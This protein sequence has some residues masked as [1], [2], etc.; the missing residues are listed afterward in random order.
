MITFGV[1][2][3]TYLAGWIVIPEEGEGASIAENLI[4]KT[5]SS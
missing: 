2:A 1:G 4:K 3:L 5:G